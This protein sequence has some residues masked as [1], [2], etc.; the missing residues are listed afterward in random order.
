MSLFNPKP[1]VHEDSYN[2]ELGHNGKRNC[3]NGGNTPL[4]S[5][6]AQE[7]D[8][9]A[10]NNKTITAVPN[11]KSIQQDK[12]N[13]KEQAAPTDIPKPRMRFQTSQG[14]QKVQETSHVTS[15]TTMSALSH[16]TSYA[17]K[18]PQNDLERTS[19]KNI[20]NRT[21]HR[22]RFERDNL[23]NELME[24]KSDKQSILSRFLF[25][26]G[27]LDQAKEDNAIGSMPKQQT[28]ENARSRLNSAKISSNNQPQSQKLL[29]Y[30][31]TGDAKAF[32][33]TSSAT[34]SA[35]KS[36]ASIRQAAPRAK[37]AGYTV[38]HRLKDTLVPNQHSAVLNF[39]RNIGSYS[40]SH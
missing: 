22:V 1:D 5:S 14:T 32:A 18:K 11:E 25:D 30:R 24:D 29:R 36:A 38:I 20:P 39:I 16:L 26:L 37:A 15:D 40:L 19:A 17:P 7:L 6:N 35:A 31:S 33:G 3:P 28:E 8:E 27:H 9:K 34:K 4:E 13:N 10:T 2:Q 21:Q 23:D 12:E